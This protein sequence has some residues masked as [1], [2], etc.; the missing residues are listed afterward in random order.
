MDCVFDGISVT[1]TKFDNCPDIIRYKNVLVL[2]R[3]M[4]QNLGVTRYDAYN[5]VSNGS[6]KIII[7]IHLHTHIYVERKK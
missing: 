3:Y 5:P 4:L 2:R 1:F 6:A 7:I